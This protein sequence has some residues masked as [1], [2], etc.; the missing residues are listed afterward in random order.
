MATKRPQI[1]TLAPSPNSV[2]SLK[3]EYQL[4]L[5]NKDPLMVAINNLFTF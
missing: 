2:V 5:P 4:S 3:A 1:I